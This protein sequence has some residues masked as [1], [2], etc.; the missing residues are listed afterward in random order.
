MFGMDPGDIDSI[1]LALDI[2][3]V[4]LLFV[5]ELPSGVKHP[6]TPGTLLLEGSPSPKE[7]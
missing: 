1:G 3:G 5:F 2:A 4:V 7:H 6:D